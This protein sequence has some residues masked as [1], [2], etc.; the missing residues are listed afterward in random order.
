MWNVPPS[1]KSPLISLLVPPSCV[2]IALTALYFII[3]YF[4]ISN[5]CFKDKDPCFDIH[6]NNWH[7]LRAYFTSGTVLSILC[8]LFYFVWSSKNYP[9]GTTIMLIFFR[10]KPKHREVKKLMQTNR[11]ESGRARIRLQA[12]WIQSLCYWPWGYTTAPYIM[13]FK[14]VHPRCVETPALWQVFSTVCWIE[15]NVKKLSGK[16][17]SLRILRVSWRR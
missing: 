12:V 7:F 11:L 13:F 10:M 2:F 14:D 3:C 1:V 4:L 6:S 9:W 8:T 5:N 17:K 16:E 15:L